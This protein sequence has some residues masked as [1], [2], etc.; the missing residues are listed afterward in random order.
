MPISWSPVEGPVTS[1]GSFQI[2]AGGG[3]VTLDCIPLVDCYVETIASLII[4]END[5]SGTD[6]TS[7]GNGSEVFQVPAGI[8]RLYFENGSATEPTIFLVRQMAP[9]SIGAV[10]RTPLCALL[11]STDS[12]PRRL[13]GSFYGS[14]GR[15][16]KSGTTTQFALD[17]TDTAQALGNIVLSRPNPPSPNHLW[18]DCQEFRGVLVGGPVLIVEG[19]HIANAT[20]TISSGSVSK[21]YPGPVVLGGSPGIWQPATNPGYMDPPVTATSVSSISPGSAASQ[22]TIDITSSVLASL[23]VSWT[24]TYASGSVR[25]LRIRAYRKAVTLD[26]TPLTVTSQIASVDEVFTLIDTASNTFTAHVELDQGLYSVELS[27]PSG[28]NAVHATSINWY[29]QRYQ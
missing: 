5:A 19:D 11:K 2:P 28:A 3:G 25:S 7:V 4:R 6:I 27:V 17:I 22:F 26:A 12:A 20:G 8:S 23:F 14:D 1:A 29:L 10:P 15:L 18:T 24:Q 16:L 21:I 13:I 9:E